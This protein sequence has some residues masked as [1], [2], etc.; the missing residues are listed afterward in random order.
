G[1]GAGG[2][3]G[4]D[5]DDAGGMGCGTGFVVDEGDGFE[6]RLRSVCGRVDG[7][8]GGRGWG[9]GDGRDGGD[10]DALVV[11]DV[12]DVGLG[13]RLNEHVYVIAGFRV[14]AKDFELHNRLL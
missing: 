7:G 8:G 6:V 4:V 12:F 9:R 14:G 11:G 5:G 3:V 10:E 13:G 1:R 2:G